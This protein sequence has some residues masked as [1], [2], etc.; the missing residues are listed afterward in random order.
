MTFIAE[1]FLSGCISKVI[2]DC[3]DY[4]WLK[5]KEVISNKNDRSV[6]TRIYR[7]IEKTLIKV[8]DKEF[9]SKD[10]LYETIEKIFIEFR[11]NGSTIESVRCG[12]GILSL[13]VTT[14]RCK[15]FLEKFYEELCQDDDLYKVISLVLQEKGIQINQKEFKQLNETVEYGF[16]NLNRKIDNLSDSSIENNSNNEDNEI[17]KSLKFQ[18]NRKQK[19]IENWNSRLFLHVNNDENPITL[20]DAFIVPKF[21][22]RISIDNIKIFDKDLLT[23]SLEKFIDYDKTSNLL[24]TGSPGI[25]KTSIISWIANRYKCNDDIIVLRF[26]D[27]NNKDLQKGLLNAIYHS[28]NCEKNSLENKILVLDGFDEIK[29]VS[30]RKNLVREFLNDSLDFDNLK[31]IVTSRHNYLNT[32]D[33]QIHFEILPFNILQIQEFYQIIKG[34]ELDK[35]KIDCDNLDVLGIPVILYMAIMVNIDLTTK[36]TRPEL[37]SRIFAKKGGIFDR[38]NFKGSGYDNGFQPLRDKENVNKYLGFLQ[39]VAF[40]MFEKDNLV[41]TKTEYDIPELEIQGEKLN[42][43]EFPI[44][45]LFESDGYNIEF[46]HKSI[47]EYFISEY[48]LMRIQQ[49]L[50][51]SKED[52]AG[53]LG[54]MLKRSLLSNEILEYLKFKIRGKV[55]GAFDSIYESFQLMIRNGMTYYTDNI[56]QNIIDCEMNVFNNMLNIIHLW[57]KSILELDRDFI[58]YINCNKI[59]NFQNNKNKINLRNVS[60]NEKYLRCIVL[61]GVDLSYADLSHKDLQSADLSYSKLRN[62]NLNYAELRSANLSYSDLQSAEL[63]NTNLSK[64]NLRGTI[65]GKNDVKKVI[66]QLKKAKFVYIIVVDKGKQKRVYRRELFFDKKWMKGEES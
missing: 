13:G 51:K 65:W 46:I 34:V 7:V 8:T 43:I 23:D 33:F 41:L 10:I 45:P 9:K 50:N 6:S 16:D 44:K 35:N 48:F 21:D 4:S 26:R 18:Y 66:Q 32:Y 52:I 47:Y 38:L 55:V 2:N 54:C 63:E 37:Y 58:N 17:A 27:W 53:D 24:I 29:L 30:K 59:L 62:T 20:A 64:A 28:L 5:I 19:Y 3:K 36:A 39:Q 25:G 40:L 31:I 60:F 49:V 42:I 57:N 56:D 11:D 61:R 22:C 15:N 14:E 1:A 12:L